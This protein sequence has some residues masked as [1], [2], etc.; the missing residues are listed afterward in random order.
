MKDVFWYRERAVPADVCDRIVAEHVGGVEDAIVYSRAKD[1]YVPNLDKRRSKVN[2]E[3]SA[4][5]REICDRYITQANREH[6][7]VHLG[8]TVEC[9]FTM[10]SH[11]DR[12]WYGWHVDSVDLGA[13]ARKLSCIVLLSDPE[14]Y[15]G[16]ALQIGYD[17]PPV[18]PSQGTVVVFPSPTLHQVQ[19]VTDGFRFSLV[20]WADGPHWR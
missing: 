19:P 12:G 15:A 18:R 6:F 3:V 7:G 1:A 5:A 8:R 17:A 20:G 14:D 9:Q 4:E 11:E 10:Y 16:G 13:F 2:F